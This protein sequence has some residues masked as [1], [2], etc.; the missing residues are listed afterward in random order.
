MNH[1]LNSFINR[2]NVIKKKNVPSFLVTYSPII[3]D[4]LHLLLHEG[5]IIK[6][7]IVDHSNILI[8]LNPNCKF[9]LKLFKKTFNIKNIKKKYFSLIFST[10]KGF[11]FEDYYY[12]KNI[13]KGKPMFIIIH[14]K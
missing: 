13:P 5:F 10:S 8:H 9:Q 3:L 12:F 2:I 11:F 4:L 1:I 6:I 14:E 7:S